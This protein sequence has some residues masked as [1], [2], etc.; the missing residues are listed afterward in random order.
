MASMIQDHTLTPAGDEEKKKARHFR[1]A[2]GKIASGGQ[3][4]SPP[5]PFLVDIWFSISLNLNI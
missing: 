1:P 4:A 2:M 3:S 5:C